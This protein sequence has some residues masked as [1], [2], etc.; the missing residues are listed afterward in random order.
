MN[1]Y[2]LDTSVL[3]AILDPNHKRHK[4]AIAVAKDM[5]PGSTQYV[6]AVSLAEFRFGVRLAELTGVLQAPQL[7]RVLTDAGKYDILDVTRHTADAYSE[8]KSRMATEYLKNATRRKRPRWIE[9]W[10][11]R[12]TGKK[13]Q[14]DEND[15]WQCAQAKERDCVFV[16]ADTGI[17]RIEA[18]DQDLRVRIV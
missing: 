5:A 12:A 8:L 17:K 13:L 16:T 14:I 18:V 15:L 11:D 10:V 6:S 2:I 3:S 4:G 7:R 9:D 1:A